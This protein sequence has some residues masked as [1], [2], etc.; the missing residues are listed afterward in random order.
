[1]FGPVS[2]AMFFFLGFASA[3]LIGLPVALR[4]KFYGVVVLWGLCVFT[5][6]R[7][8]ELPNGQS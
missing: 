3:F 5:A 7:G 1:L 8:I 4:F 6:C 2:K